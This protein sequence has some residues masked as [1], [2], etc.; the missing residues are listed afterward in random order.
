M[1]GFCGIRALAERR[2]A[3]QACAACPVVRVSR[4]PPFTSNFRG[5]TIAPLPSA[6]ALAESSGRGGFPRR[7]L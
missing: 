4:D 6:A 5:R 7:C 1:P 2:R 3:E